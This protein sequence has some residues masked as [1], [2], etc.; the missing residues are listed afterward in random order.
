V[1]NVLNSD[2]L[3]Q[4]TR[5]HGEQLLREAEAERLV[6]RTRRG[7][8]RQRRRRLIT[9]LAPRLRPQRQA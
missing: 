8:L 5:D 7:V 6:R 3:R 2:E 1:T 9:A 4:L